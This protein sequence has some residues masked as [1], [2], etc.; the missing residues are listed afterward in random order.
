[1]NEPQAF[2]STDGRFDQIMPP[3]LSPPLKVGSGLGIPS[4]VA[5]C[6]P[7]SAVSTSDLSGPVCACCGKSNT[8]NTASRC[9][10]TDSPERSCMT[11]S[12][13]QPGDPLYYSHDYNQDR[14]YP[15]DGPAQALTGVRRT[16]MQTETSPQQVQPDQTSLLSISS[17]E[18][19]PART[20]VLQAT[21]RDLLA[22]VQDYG[23]SS[24]VSLVRSLPAG[25]SSRTSLACYPATAEPTLPSSF[26]GWRSSGM[27]GPTGFWTLNTSEWPNDADVCS[28]SDVLETPGP[29]LERYTLSARACRG[30]L[31]RAEKRGREL[32]K[33]LYH[34]LSAVSEV[35]TIPEPTRERPS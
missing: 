24:I 34:A 21:E 11:M 15:T 23:T 17:A 30:I 9:C 27:G 31:R 29:H 3:G 6:F 8:T 22:S 2:Y 13:K 26:Q 5:V 10:D 18:D 28:L 12:E 35:E 7:V 1:M 33:A 19:S 25:F 32:P 16:Y 20:L 14:V 4:P